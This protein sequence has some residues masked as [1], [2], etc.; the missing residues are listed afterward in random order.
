MLGTHIQGRRCPI[1]VTPLL[2]YWVIFV[3]YVWREF[4]SSSLKPKRSSTRSPLHYW[5]CA[6]RHRDRRRVRYSNAEETGSLTPHGP[7]IQEMW[8]RPCSRKDGTKLTSWTWST[9]G[10]SVC[11]NICILLGFPFW[12]NYKYKKYQTHEIYSTNVLMNL[13]FGIKIGKKYP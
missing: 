11:K 6:Q 5:E 10:F 1:S 9:E 2:H 13:I 4:K 12:F 7:G 3:T 8:E